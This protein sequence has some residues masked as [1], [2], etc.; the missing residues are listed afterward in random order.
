MEIKKKTIDSILFYGFVLLVVLIIFSGLTGHGLNLVIIENADPNSM[1]PTYKQGD[2]FLLQQPSYDRYNLGDVIVY[3]SSN[4]NIIHR[5]IDIVVINNYYYFRVK[6]DDPITNPAPDKRGGT[7]LIPQDKV[8]GRIVFHIPQL[9]FLSLAIQKNPVV[10]LLA[11]SIAIIITLFILF[12]PDK[13]D[14]TSDEKVN[15]TPKSI[16]S[17]IIS[18]FNNY[19]KKFKAIYNNNQLFTIIAS[20][21]II[22]MLFTPIYLP[23]MLNTNDAEKQSSVVSVTF[24]SPIL[25]S[26]YINNNDETFVFIQVKVQFIDH[27]GPLSHFKS[28][29]LDVYTDSNYNPESQISHTQWSTLYDLKGTFTVGASVVIHYKDIPTE[30]TTLYFIVSYNIDKIFKTDNY[31]YTGAYVFIPPTGIFSNLNHHISHIITT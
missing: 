14:E 23:G 8:I 13:E 31:M 18:Y 10:R 6:G 7:T 5:I 16:I 4:G 19:Y 20:I 27:T 9:G 3:E 12:V 11:F 30:K 22:I 29:S 24:G 2:L 26:E 17:G 28:F 21:L 1:Y 15:I 25:Y